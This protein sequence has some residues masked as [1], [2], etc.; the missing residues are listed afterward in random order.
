MLM[1]NPLYWLFVGPAILLGL[2]AQMRVKSAFAKYSRVRSYSGVTGAEAARQMLEGQGVRVVASARLASQLD[3]AVAIEQVNGVLSDHYD[4]RSKVLRLSPNVYGSP[5]IAAVGV[6]CHEA[7]H[8]LQH[9]RGYAPLSARSF[10]VPVASFGSWAALPIII[11]GAMFSPPMIS[12][13]IALYA[14]LVLFQLITLPVEFNAS[15]RAKE[16]LAN[17]GI[18]R[19]QAE[20]GGVSAVLNAAALTYVAAAVSSIMTL[21]YFLMVFSGRRN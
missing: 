17:A 14:A 8:A 3:N 6:A 5:S 20:A 2:Y 15:S 10:M 18:I 1:F 19:G 12:L 11:L 16:A 21:L 9:A 4:P 7:G 13:G